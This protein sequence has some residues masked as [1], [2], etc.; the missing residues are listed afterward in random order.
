[1]GEFLGPTRG[2]LGP[3]L[4]IP[5]FIQHWKEYGELRLLA[6]EALLPWK[7]TVAY[8]AS[9]DERVPRPS[10]PKCPGKS[11]K[12]GSFAAINI[13]VFLF[14]IILGRRTLLQKIS[15]GF[16]GKNGTPA[17]PLTAFLSAFLFL[18][19]NLINAAII[20]DT[21]GYSGTPKGEL[22]LLW[23]TRP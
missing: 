8:N 1:M 15:C 17:W 19:G 7:W 4:E 9:L 18:M 21:P 22:M 6:D 5:I 20:H 23:C 2:D 11:S 14:T 10:P 16:L 12:L 13:V 3:A